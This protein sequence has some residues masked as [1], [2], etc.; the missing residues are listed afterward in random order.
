MTTLASLPACVVRIAQLQQNPIDR[1]ALLQAVADVKRLRPRSVKQTIN[2]LARV[3]FVPQPR[4]LRK[5]DPANMPLLAHHP[6]VGW[7]VVRGQND[8]GKWIIETWIEDQQK[9]AESASDMA[10]QKETQLVKLS[11]FQP[12]DCSKSCL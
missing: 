11:L 8:H 4:W 3:L 10:T 2:T 6:M 9:F 7:F 5:P 1:S 12:F